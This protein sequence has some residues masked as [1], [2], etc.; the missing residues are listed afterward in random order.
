M[1]LSERIADAYNWLERATGRPINRVDV[2][3][4]AQLEAEIERLREELIEAQRGHIGPWEPNHT[5]SLGGD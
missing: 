5:K 1:K 4:V 3:Q 2:E